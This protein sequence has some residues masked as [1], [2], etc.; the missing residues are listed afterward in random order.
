MS[1]AGMKTSGLWVLT[2]AAEHNM[3]HDMKRQSHIQPTDVCVC[4]CVCS[5]SDD[6]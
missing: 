6:S 5:C 2:T 4:V 1:L 3:T